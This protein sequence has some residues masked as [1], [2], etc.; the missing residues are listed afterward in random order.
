MSHVSYND[1]KKLSDYFRRYIIPIV[2]LIENFPLI[3]FPSDSELREEF[4][5]ISFDFSLDYIKNIVSYIFLNEKWRGW[6]ISY[7]CK[8]ISFNEV[9]KR[10]TIEDKEQANNNKS[11]KNNKRKKRS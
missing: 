11:H 5:N 6:K 1:S 3:R 4:L 7:F 9:I 8:M 2:K 10:G